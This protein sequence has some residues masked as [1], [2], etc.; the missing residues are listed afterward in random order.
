M[1]LLI[2]LIYFLRY[3]YTFQP[4]RFYICSVTSK[5]ILKTPL[6]YNRQ[7]VVLKCDGI[8]QLINI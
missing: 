2:E 6:G 4:L 3:M 5:G 1:C 7:V 8:T